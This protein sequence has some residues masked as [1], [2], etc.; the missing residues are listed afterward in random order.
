MCRSAKVPVIP[1][2]DPRFD[3]DDPRN[4]AISER[5]AA[6]GARRI[7]VKV[8]SSLVTNEGAASMPRPSAT[9]AGSWPRWPA[10]GARW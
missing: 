10:R 2:P 4:A 7:V 5:A 9:G 1:E 6:E 8:G 3:A